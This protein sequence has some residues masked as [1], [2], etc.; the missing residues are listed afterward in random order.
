[1]TIGG[2]HGSLPNYKGNNQVVTT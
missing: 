2:L 1:M